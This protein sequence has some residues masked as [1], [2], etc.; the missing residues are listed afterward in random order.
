[1]QDNN[2]MQRLQRLE[3][4]AALRNLID[5]FSNLADQK[6]IAS[7]VLLFTEDA[8]VDS[9]FGAHLVSSLTGREKIGGA[10]GAYLDKFDTVYHQNGQQTVEIDGDTATGVSYC[11]V[12]LIGTEDGKRVQNTSGVHYN[13]MYVRSG[14]TWLIAKRTAH[15]S[16]QQ[17]TDVPAAT[18]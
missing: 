1:M 2:F 17:R 3:D 13:D 5:T 15:F 14:A 18:A 8:T 10:F 4:I 6:D 7:Q 9:Y 12:A 11:L 16:W